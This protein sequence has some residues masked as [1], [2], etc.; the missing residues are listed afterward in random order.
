MGTLPLLPHA[1]TPPIAVQSIEAAVLG[2]EHGWLRLRW[3]LTGTE[4]LTVPAFAGRGRE[5]GLWRTTCF[6]LFLREPGAATYLEFNLSP[7]ERWAAYA[8]SDYRE[9][10]ADLPMPRDPDCTLRRGGAMAFF[11][12]A[13]PL[14]GLPGLPWQLGLTA[15]IEED[16]GHLSYW[17][18]AHAP[19]KPDFHAP[20]CFAA[21]LPA[22]GGA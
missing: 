2:M 9:G 3:K 7:S 5:D 8:F 18:L 22:P 4:R 12:A 13:I 15:V 21:T 19:G 20:T 17:A 11:D 14:A 16:G 10:A 1:A 6:E